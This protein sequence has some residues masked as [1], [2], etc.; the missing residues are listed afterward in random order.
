MLTLYTV[1][2]R[3]HGT[4]GFIKRVRV[5]DSAYTTGDISKL[6]SEFKSGSVDKPVTT[7]TP[8]VSKGDLGKVDGRL[9]EV[10]KLL[11]GNVS[12]EASY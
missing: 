11:K 7:P 1:L 6:Y 4:R 5:W 8:G 12:T 10:E 3:R 9:A 2:G